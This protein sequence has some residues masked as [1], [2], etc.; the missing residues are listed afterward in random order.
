VI[1]I[2]AM[3]MMLFLLKTKPWYFPL[4]M[5]T[6][7]NLD[8]S[9]ENTTLF[10]FSNI[11]YISTLFA[12]NI[13]KPYMKPMYTN[14]ILS[15]WITFSVILSYYI[16]IEPSDFMIDFLDLAYIP[17]EYRFELAF[18]T[19]VNFACSYLF[20]KIIVKSLIDFWGRKKEHRKR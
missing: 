17:K 12:Y 11:Q 13:A 3:L 7:E 1:H 8:V 5:S 14:V 9:Y 6:E 20:E 18:A 16:I 4:V 2:T 15:T 10:L 19:F